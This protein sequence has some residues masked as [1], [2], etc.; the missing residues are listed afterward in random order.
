[1][2]GAG[3]LFWRSSETRDGDENWTMGAKPKARRLAS[4][5]EAAEFG[6][7]AGFR[8][9]D[10]LDRR[11]LQRSYEASLVPGLQDSDARLADMDRAGVAAHASSST[12][13]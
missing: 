7:V 5:A 12:A 8:N 11:F 13:A 9:P 4:D 6:K 10:Q 1:M 2:V 3:L